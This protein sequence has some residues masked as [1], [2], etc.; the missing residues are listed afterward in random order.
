MKKSEQKLAFLSARRSTRRIGRSARAP[1]RAGRR[2]G[3]LRQAADD[4][5]RDAFR[6]VALGL[7]LGGGQRRGE[8]PLLGLL[9]FDFLHLDLRLQRRQ[10]LLCGGG[11]AGFQLQQFLLGRRHRGGGVGQ[12]A[13]H[14]GVGLRGFQQR[15]LRG[16]FLGA[17]LMRRLL[18]RCALGHQVGLLLL[19]IGAGQRYG[20][21]ILFRLQTAGD[22]FR[23]AHLGRRGA[24]LLRQ[25]L[26]D[27]RQRV[28]LGLDEFALGRQQRL[29]R[30]G[31]LLL[32]LHALELHFTELDGQARLRRQSLR[33]GVLLFRFQRHLVGDHLGGGALLFAG[34]GQALLGVALVAQGGDLRLFGFDARFGGGRR[35]LLH[36]QLVLQRG[37]CLPLGFSARAFGGGQRG[38]LGGRLLGQRFREFARGGV[39]G[40]RLG[41]ALARLCGVGIASGAIFRK[42]GRLAL[43]G[44]GG[45]G[46][47]RGRVFGQRGDGALFRRVFGGGAFGGLA[48]Q[49]GAFVGQLRGQF[50]FHGLDAGRFGRCRLGLL[51]LLGL[52]QRQRLG[53]DP[54]VRLQL[55]FLLGGRAGQR[56]IAQLAF[57]FDARLGRRQD[58]RLGIATRLHAGGGHHLHALAVDRRVADFLFGLQA[59]MQRLRGAALRL[60]LRQRDLLALLFQ[61]RQRAGLFQRAHL[62][63]GAVE[64]R[65]ERDLVGAFALHGQLQRLGFGVGQHLRG[66][67]RGV[68]VAF[69]F[70]RQ[71]GDARVGRRDADHLFAR[72][73]HGGDAFDRVQPGAFGL[74]V[75]LVGGARGLLR[76]L[77]F[78][79]DLFGGALAVFFFLFGALLGGDADR[80][81][82]F[83]AGAQ[84]GRLLLDR[85]EAGHAGL[86]GVAQR[87]EALAVGGDGFFRSLCVL[88]RDGGGGGDHRGAVLGQRTGARLGVGAV[89]GGAG[90]LG[91]GFDAGDRLVYGFHLHR[92]APRR[93]HGRLLQDRHQIKRRVLRRRLRFAIG[94]VGDG[95][96]GAFALGQG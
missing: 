44:Q 27:Q 96:E 51:Q 77:R 32:D 13:L 88:Q 37:Q 73:L 25:F 9:A 64:G 56:H 79:G 50:V 82:G 4:V 21:H 48:R 52:H 87:F 30:L 15:L 39:F 81:V 2:F 66:L 19:G 75:Q 45:G 76:Q 34:G 5:A 12:L 53:F 22:R 38:R 23:G 41:F 72:G 67:A 84:L 18:R 92:R 58:A 71:R 54:G 68:G 91:V 28:T 63:G 3:R 62:G 1:H 80:G 94:G 78:D 33:G 59:Q 47:L 24:A 90:G 42:G 31:L 40:L 6:C 29:R 55:R 43:L 16:R 8:R 46:I 65:F 7:G 70:A 26:L 83:D 95:K 17:G 57:G 69:A 10:R 85:F 36:L 49:R 11:A 20:G 35:G 89:L 86:G 14:Y 61:M 93:G 60:G 74:R